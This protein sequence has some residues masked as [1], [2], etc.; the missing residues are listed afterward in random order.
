MPRPTVYLSEGEQDWLDD[1]KQSR[2]GLI[3]EAVRHYRNRQMVWLGCED[4][5]TQPFRAQPD[6]STCPYC[7]SE[8][9]ETPTDAE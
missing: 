6:A 1:Q 2:S 3:R 9:T 5:C 7:G 4:D 8:A